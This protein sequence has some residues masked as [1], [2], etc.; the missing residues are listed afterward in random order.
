MRAH[1]PSA[2]FCPGRRPRGTNG[3]PAG[4]FCPCGGGVAGSSVDARN[5]EDIVSA[6]ELGDREHRVLVAAGSAAPSIHNTQPW[7]FVATP[8]A[9]EVHADP[10]R[11]L[12]VIDPSARAL[13]IS[14]GAAVLNL[15]VALAFLGRR[16]RVRWLPS[17]AVP[18]HLAT[19]EVV[20]AR[21]TRAMDREL[22]GALRRRSSSRQPMTSRPV[23]AGLMSQ[24]R[25]AVRR[26]GAELHVLSGEDADTLVT[27]AHQ[28]DA[29]QRGDH[30]YR[31]ELGRWT[32]ADPA[33]RDGVPAS[34]FGAA[35]GPEQAP[36]RDFTQGG[37]AVDRQEEAFEAAP[38][39]AVVTTSA[40]TVGDWLR[41]GMALQHLLL[42]ATTHWL[43][44]GFLTQPLELPAFRDQVRGLIDPRRMP[45]VVLRVG[46]GPTPPRSPRRPLDEVLAPAKPSQPMP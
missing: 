21:S 20:G 26:E 12:G 31:E 5:E 22:Y 14:C 16:A 29:S 34:A 35:P 46:Y 41:A 1:H 4:T 24:L 25:E 45:Q 3:A 44:A 10:A 23:P 39:L 32:T 19:V 40:D 17:P 27:I 2:P 30:A 13:V 42:V 11:G 8:R 18:T 37:V 7:R 33:R 38:M 36:Q 9:I 28:A 43:R 15:R 6:I